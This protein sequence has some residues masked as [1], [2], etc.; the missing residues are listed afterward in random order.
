M[1]ICNLVSRDVHVGDRA[2]L[3]E[4]FPDDL[5]VDARLQVADVDGSFLIPLEEGPA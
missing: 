5:L 2:G 4:E 3:Q 1:L